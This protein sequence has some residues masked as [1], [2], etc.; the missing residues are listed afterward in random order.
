VFEADQL[1]FQQ[2]VLDTS[3]QTP[4][5]VDFW[6]P[7]CG[8]C[9]ALGPL[10]ERL[11]EAYAGRFKLVKV[12]SDENPDLAAQY[13]VRSIPYVI[14]FLGGSPVDSFVGALPEAQLRA[15]IDRVMPSPAELER[16]KAQQHLERGE[17]EAA[18]SAL[19]AAVALDP[20]NTEARLDLAELLLE[21]LPP[22]ADVARLSEAQDQL[23]AVGAGERSDRRWRALDMRLSSL[24]SATSLPA[25][26]ELQARVEAEPSDLQARLELAQQHIAHRQLQGALDQLL[27]IVGRDR[28]FGDD[29]ARRMMLSVFDLATDQPQLVSTYRRRLSAL[30][31]R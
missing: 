5:L 26:A 23:A 30:I 15:F 17:L 16:H 18:A 27:E 19:R 14:A 9:R 25:I 2:E 7:W 28:A 22:P 20:A 8:P 4:V 10:L 31:N 6:A 13:Q 1:T 21:R 3:Q 11:E 12:N 24:R 29:V